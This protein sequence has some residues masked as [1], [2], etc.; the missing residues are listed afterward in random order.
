MVWAPYVTGNNTV[1]GIILRISTLANYPVQ[2]VAEEY[3]LQKFNLETKLT[4]ETCQKSKHEK[5]DVCKRVFVS[6]KT[7]G[8]PL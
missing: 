6:H 5:C 8:T 3:N 2:N 7:H 4:K 1:V